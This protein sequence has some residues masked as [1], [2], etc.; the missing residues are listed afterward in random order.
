[1]HPQK[2]KVEKWAL[3]VGSSFARHTLLAST[4]PLNYAHGR[5]PMHPQ[6]VKEEKWALVVGSAFARHTLLASTIPLKLCT[7]NEDTEAK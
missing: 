4:I 1:M 6:K 5:T 7:K 3:V 2:V